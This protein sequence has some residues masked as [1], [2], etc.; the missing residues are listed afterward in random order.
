V[1]G[2]DRNSET[3][4]TLTDYVSLAWRGRRIII[5]SA[6]VSSLIF[7]GISFVLPTRYE[8]FTSIIPAPKRDGMSVFS[9]LGA[10]LGDLGIRSPGSADYSTMYPEIVRSRRILD[11]L[12]DRSYSVGSDGRPVPLIDLIQPKGSGP[13]RREL[14]IRKMRELVDAVLDNRTDVLTIRVRAPEPKIAAGVANTLDSL[15]QE[16]T[17]N[18]VTTQAGQNRR[19]I[20]GRL[21]ET[22][23]SLAKAENGL[24][25]F[26]EANLRIGNSPRLLLEEGRFA[27]VLREQEEIYLTLQRQRELAKIEEYRDVPALNILDPA[28]PPVFRHSPKRGFMCLIGLMIGGLVSFSFLVARSL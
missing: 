21:A 26:R 11:R 20:E 16:F 12:L 14:A 13:K 18:S 19:F 10:N 24:R 25:E 15:L 7:L 8:A 4:K 27:R 6:F 1:S 3:A 22:A 5:T 2:E 28:V 17:V 23:N 9:Q